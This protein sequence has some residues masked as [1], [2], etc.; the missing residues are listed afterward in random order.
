MARAEGSSSNDNISTTSL[1]SA[2][3][4]CG[5]ELE[6]TLDQEISIYDVIAE[7]RNLV[8]YQE[9]TVPERLSK[10]K[11]RTATQV[12]ASMP[13]HCYWNVKRLQV[14][15]QPSMREQFRTAKVSLHSKT[16]S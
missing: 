1:A 7:F 10:L 11:K 8:G 16:M 6:E 15:S 13:N 9:G 14:H 2:A 5:S 4:R 3:F 12:A